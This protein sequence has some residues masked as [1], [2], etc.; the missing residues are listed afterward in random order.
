MFSQRVDRILKASI[1][2]GGA[3]LTV[4]ALVLYFGMRNDVTDVG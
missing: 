3:V 4:G 1:L 2:G